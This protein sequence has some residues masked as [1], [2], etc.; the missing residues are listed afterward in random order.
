MFVVMGGL[1]EDWSGMRVPG[2]LRHT[3]QLQSR[4][5]RLLS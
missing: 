2:V 1:E 3:V 4:V 5:S